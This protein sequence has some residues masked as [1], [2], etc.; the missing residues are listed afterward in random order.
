MLHF[1]DAKQAT[2]SC[3]L[4][5]AALIDVPMRCVR[6]ANVPCGTHDSPPTQVEVVEDDDEE[7]GGMSDVDAS[8]LVGEE[9]IGH[10]GVDTLRGGLPGLGKRGQGE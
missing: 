1:Y 6:C 4:K 8:D 7:E 9:N 5:R 3:M 10:L 2:P